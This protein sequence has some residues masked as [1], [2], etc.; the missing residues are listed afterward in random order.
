MSYCELW[1]RNF[2]E[3]W[4]MV[5]GFFFSPNTSQ[6]MAFLNPLGA[7]IPKIPFSFCRM[8][9][10]GHLRSPGVSLGRILG[11]PVI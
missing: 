6:M 3:V 9:G 1:R 5:N 8:S 11:G 10:L 4:K 2:F 7:L